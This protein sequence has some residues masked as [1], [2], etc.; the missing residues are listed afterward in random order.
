MEYRIRQATLDD[1]DIITGHR[2]RMFREMGHGD[3]E[4]QR[5]AMPVYVEWLRERMENGRYQGWLMLAPDNAVVA[6]VGLWL[7]DWPTGVV[8]LA[9]FRGYVFNVWTEP[10]HRRKG[11]SR[12]LMLTLLA[13]CKAQGINRVGLHASTAGRP[14]YE[15]LG[16]TASNELTITL[17]DKDLGT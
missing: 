2:Y 11:L 14:G 10:E 15:A 3:P 9:H 13:A 5:R 8:D 17:Q 16:F 1:V 4:L 6:G 7:M 12:R